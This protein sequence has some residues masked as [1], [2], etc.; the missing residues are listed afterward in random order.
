MSGHH[1]QGP[2]ESETSSR[3]TTST[4]LYLSIGVYRRWVSGKGRVGTPPLPVDVEPRVKWGGSRSTS[5]KKGCRVSL[6]SSS[7]YRKGRGGS[8]RRSRG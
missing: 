8:T 7:R 5:R 6:Q 4:T 1:W 3:T 2:R